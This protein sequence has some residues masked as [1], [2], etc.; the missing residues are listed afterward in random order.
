MKQ[1]HKF[2]SKYFFGTLL[3][4]AMLCTLTFTTAAQ[5]TPN[6]L[7]TRTLS[8]KDTIP[9]KKDTISPKKD[10]TDRI[11]IISSDT[12]LL[13]KDSLGLSADS[14]K[15]QRTDTFSLKLSKDTLD[16]P[17]K[18]EAADSAVVLIQ[19]KKIILYGKTKTEYKDITLTAPLVEIDQQT[20][21]LTASNHRDSL[22]AVTEEANFRQG[23]NSFY[24]DTIHYNFK[25]QKGQTKNTYSL[26][27]EINVGGKVVKK[28]SEN[29]TYIKEAR[30]TTCMYD[31]PHFDI[32]TN[33]LKMINHKLAVSGPAHMEF[34]G[35]PIPIYLPF[36]FYPLN[37]GR[38]SG[39]LPPQFATNE[40]Y[41]LGLEGLGYYK[42]MNDYWDAKVYGN[43]YSY[44]GWSWNINPTYRKRYKFS[45]AFNFGI[46]H[47]KINFKG[48]PDYVAN[49]SY[50][51]T[52]NHSADS[53]ARPGTSF[54]ANVNASST[55]YNK[56]VSNN[57]TLNYS[58]LAGSSITYSK[59]WQNK[60]YNLTLSANHNQNNLTRLVNVSLPDMGFTV[61]TIYPFERKEP[62]GPKKWYE[63]LGVAYNG[64]FRNQFS[65][66][67][68]AFSFRQL[69]DTLQWGAQHN[70]PVSLSLPP[71]LGGAVMVSPGVSYSQV[72][73]NQ[74]FRRSWNDTKQKVDTTITKGF[75]IDHQA[76]FSLSFSTAIF[77][78]YE[79]KNSRIIAIRHVMRPSLS[80]SYQPDLSSS[81]FYRTQVDTSKTFATFSEFEGALYPGFGGGK[82]GGLSFQLDNNLEMKQRPKKSKELS[83]VV[84]STSLD[85]TGLNPDEEIPRIKL[86]D[87]YGLNT[88]YNFFADSLKLA[89]IQLYLRTNL[90]NKIN[91]T[92]AAT[93]DPYEVNS[94]GQDIDEYS[95]SH[96]SIGRISNANV[97][98]SSTFQSKPK[99]E[100]KEQQK[101]QQM[102]DLRN[103][104]ALLADQ[105][106]LL[107][108]MRENPAQFVDFNIPWSVSIGY[109]LYFTQV[110]RPDYSGFDKKFTSSANLNGSFNLTPKWNFSMNTF[111][112]FN[113]NKIQTFT[114]SISR[115][116]HCWQLSI[117]V[118]PTPPYKF[119][120]FTIS[121]KSGLLQD[122][123]INRSRS[124]YTGY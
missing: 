102:H 122:L 64:T 59:T 89:P 26:Q 2:S 66:Y 110:I 84:D 118:N 65:F 68:S 24:S 93:L 90:F 76:S 42:V 100:K 69:I 88:S 79:F 101:Q 54:S 86:I 18:Y 22:G 95:L 107:D 63:Q 9:P 12:S 74:K 1:L 109:T 87:G 21:V 73:I 114:M 113:T 44:G 39:L 62:V 91:I 78:K 94:L 55:Q 30:I 38:H 81:H 28:V 57:P 35:V 71:I 5:R 7:L 6:K 115:D 45:G 53:R 108:Y 16:A 41:G 3:I 11:N 15:R 37:Q 75:Y 105:Q 36:G 117:N 61:A 124:F 14:L 29:V 47:T 50:T 70:F 83:G 82:F 4:V 13:S 85:S 112:D 123:K 98:I 33:K 104:P 51:L 92:A 27:G 8:P 20:Q 60:P 56:Y 120:S 97:S 96:G 52:W 121:P 58:A 67:D 10:S 106:R 40:Q 25:T 80:M 32:K 99:D 49:N 48:D 19:E 111:Y 77:G 103:D 72:W 43:V 17:V 116:M 23:E 119:F 31:D 46:Q 34:E